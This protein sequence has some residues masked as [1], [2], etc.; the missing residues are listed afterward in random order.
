M[1]LILRTILKFPR[2]FAYPEPELASPSKQSIPISPLLLSNAIVKVNI[3]RFR[4][5]LRTPSHFCFLADFGHK[6]YNQIGSNPSRINEKKNGEDQAGPKKEIQS[7]SFD[8][9]PAHVSSGLLVLG[10][11]ERV[12]VD[13]D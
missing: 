13:R 8:N 2:L 4:L 11:K 6:E 1:V 5:L 10:R 12:P 9:R 3:S 7:G